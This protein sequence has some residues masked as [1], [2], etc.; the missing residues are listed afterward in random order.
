MDA[1]L[2]RFFDDLDVSSEYPGKNGQAL[3]LQ[4]T[5]KVITQLFCSSYPDLFQAKEIGK[6]Y[7]WDSRSYVVG[8]MFAANKEAIEKIDDLTEDIIVNEMV[9]KGLINNEQIALGYLIKAHGDLFAVFVNE[10]AYKG[11]R[12]YELINILGN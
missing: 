11:H 12:N 1:G 10:G 3:L 4:N 2:S 6:E 5:S 7:F 9:N 8:G